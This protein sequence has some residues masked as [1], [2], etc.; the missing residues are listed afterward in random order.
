MKKF[1]KKHIGLVVL[2]VIVLAFPVSM[3]TQARLNMRIIVTGLAIDKTA[4]GYEVTAQIVKTKPSSGSSDM[5]A[6][7]EFVSDTGETLV[8]A[9]SK[10]A[11][12]SGKVAGF[13]HTNF[14]L[15]GKEMLSND[16][17]KE[18][19]YFLR[20][21]VIKDSVLLAVAKENAKDEIKKTKDLS[22]SVAL[23]LQKVFVYKE[24]ESDS[25]MT[26]LLSFMNDSLGFSQT[27]MVSTLQFDSGEE[28]SST[29]E[30]SSVDEKSSEQSSSDENSS[31]GS[32]SGQSSGSSNEK[33][34]K[35]GEQEQSEKQSEGEESS[36]SGGG[37]EEGECG[38]SYFSS[39]SPIA[40]FVKGKYVGSLETEDEILGFLYSENKCRS[41]DINVENINFG[42][43]KNAKVGVKIKYK[44]SSKKLSFDGVEPRLDIVVN[45]LNSSIKE[46][47]NEDFVQVL[48]QEEFEYI[49]KQ[50]AQ[51]IAEKIA[52]AFEKS[53]QMKADIFGA[54]DLANK[55]QYKITS[56]NYQTME[57]FLDSL[58][59]NVDVRLVRLEY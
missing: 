31:G 48:T 34:T 42:A 30:E 23:G 19:N 11:Y 25:I 45:I 8:S 51:T 3:S 27:A 16:L 59:L 58:K 57:E 43:L 24:K 17:V 29:S 32:Q 18:L 13:S 46:L 56:K 49:K 14:I 38:S 4:D 2:L 40:C 35:N 5:G 6:S 55:Y 1:L 26:S 39:L 36:G 54:Y 21:T 52:K 9:I 50:I 15:I 53:K 37:S 7:I 22:L 12:R 33:S 41:D 47:Q 10:L 28:N 20:D 44:T